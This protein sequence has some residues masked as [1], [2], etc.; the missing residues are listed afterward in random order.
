[1]LEAFLSI[2]F[3]SYTFFSGG[4][5][6]EEEMGLPGI[7]KDFAKSLGLLNLKDFSSNVLNQKKMILEADLLLGADDLTCQILKGIYPENE[8]VSIEGQA[9]R[10][11]V[12]LTDPVN[13]VGYEFNHL[14]GRFLYF[15]FSSFRE[16]ECQINQSPIT[17]LIANQDNIYSELVILLESLSIGGTNPLIVDCNFKF[18]TKNECIRLVPDSQRYEA[19]ADSIVNLNE[20]DLSAISLIGPS[21]EVTSWESLVASPEWRRWLIDISRYRPILLLC[22]PVDVIDG[23]KHNSFLEALNAD[24]L[25]YRA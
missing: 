7:T 21:H 5:I 22:T 8:F 6:G 25:V 12:R 4:I 1:V 15:G 23:E 16:S 14:L 24:R 17:A 2:H 18:A 19:V 11:G 10:M 20:E 13:T 3:S 9:R